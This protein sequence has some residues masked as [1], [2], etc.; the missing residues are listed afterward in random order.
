M[1]TKQKQRANGKIAV[2]TYE[3]TVFDEAPAGPTLSDIHVTETFSGDINGDGVVHF[4]QAAQADGS[5]TFVGIER[6]RGSIG[7]K[8]GKRSGT[9][10]LQDHG[11]VVGKQVKGEWFVV[12]GS[13]TGDLAGLR[14]EGGFEAELGQHATIWL[15][16]WFEPS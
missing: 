3:P 13:G 1:S 9:F 5:A 10:L 15:D 11:T 2:K 7:G 8:D 6:V 14:G 4:V 12:P 16:Y